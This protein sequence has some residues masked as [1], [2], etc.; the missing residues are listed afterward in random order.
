ML[1]SLNVNA[2]WV[3]QLFAGLL[4]PATKLGQGY[5][6]TGV[7]HSVNR[8]GVCLST[9]WDTYPGSRHPPPEQTPPQSRPPWS[10]HPPRSRHPPGADTPPS[11]HPPGADI[12]PRMLGDT[13]ILLEC[14]LVLYIFSDTMFRFIWQLSK[15]RSVIGC[16]VRRQHTLVSTSK[17]F[18]RALPLVRLIVSTIV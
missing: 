5:V 4:L 3:C 17:N 12:P 1:V 9:C 18:Q 10:R 7:C 8:G 13:V 6:F 15:L 14:N 2:S 16:Y 11:R